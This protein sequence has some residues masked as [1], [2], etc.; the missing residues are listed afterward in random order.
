VR[1][2]GNKQ[3]RR[4]VDRTECRWAIIFRDVKLAVYIKE[5]DGEQNESGVRRSGVLIYS[6]DYALA[7]GRRWPKLMLG[8]PPSNRNPGRLQIGIVGRH[9]Y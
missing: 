8:W 1:E 2:R 4:K 3:L 5:S 6:L 7:W 9:S